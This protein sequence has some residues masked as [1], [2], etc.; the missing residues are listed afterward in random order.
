MAGAAHC[1]RVI[2]PPSVFPQDSII[3]K[4]G[5]EQVSNFKISAP[6]VDIRISLGRPEDIG[7][8]NRFL[9]KMLQCNDFF[10]NLPRSD[11]LFLELIVLIYRFFLNFVEITTCKSVNCI[12]I[13]NLM[14][15]IIRM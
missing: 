5:P 11:S 3:S 8:K 15:Y 2:H 10:F 1:L 14:L 12:I 9:R 7:S 4:F 6:R 13:L